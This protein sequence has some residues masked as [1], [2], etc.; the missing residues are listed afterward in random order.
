M[1]KLSFRFWG[2][3]I[4]HLLIQ[5]FSLSWYSAPN[6]SGSAPKPQFQ[7]GKF[8]AGPWDLNKRNLY[9]KLAP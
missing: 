1:V 2:N 6:P 8:S 4:K 7:E 3:L 9:D 5:P